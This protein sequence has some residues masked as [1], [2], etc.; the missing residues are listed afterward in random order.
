MHR[1]QSARQGLARL[2]GKRY[3]GWL[4]VLLYLLAALYLTAPI[5]SALTLRFVGAE[6]GDTYD[7]VRQVWWFKTALLNGDDIFEQSL[8]AYPEGFRSVRLWANPLQFFP[9]WLF[10][11]FLPLPAAF[12][13]GVLLTLTLNGWS[14]Y[15]LAR[16]RLTAMSRFP[17]FVAGLVF[18][19]FPTLQGYLLDG[20]I[21]MLALWPLP[22]LIVYLFDYAD[23]GGTRRF[24]IA[25]LLFVMVALGDTMRVFYVLA[26]LALLFVCARVQRRDQ[27]GA[28]RATFAVLAGCV[29][30]LLYLSPVIADLMDNPQLLTAGGRPGRSIDLLGLVSPSSANPFWDDIALHSQR[31][32]GSQLSGNA[33]Y[34]GLIGGILA[35][36]GI[37][38][39]REARW[40]LLV[41]FTAWILALGP[42]LRVNNQVLVGTVGGYPAVLPLPFAML[43]RLPIFELAQSPA[44]FMCLFAVMYALL[45]GFG[46]MVCCE[47]NLVQRRRPYARVIIAGIFV[48]MLLED[49]KLVGDFPSVTADV[50]REILDLSRQR[51]IHAVYNVPHDNPLAVNEALFLQTAHAKPLIAGLDTR[52]TTV[53]RARL[54]LLSKFQPSLLEDAGADI[55]IINKARALESGHLD[56]LHWRARQGLGDPLYEDQRYA[57]YETPVLRDGAPVVYAPLT[58]AQSHVTYIYKEQPG[59][60]EYSAVLEAQNRRVI[61][62]LNDTPLETL[63]VN[64]RIPLSFPLPMARRGYHAFRVAPDPPCPERVDTALLNCQRV[65]VEDVRITVL[66]DGA[67]YDP[68]RIEDGIILAGY[69]L[70]EAAE[71]EVIRIRFWWQFEADRSEKDVR[72]VHVLD[73][74]GRLAPGSPPDHHFGTLTAGSEVTE[75]V[76]LDKNMLEA[77]EHRVLTGWYQLPQA[78]R[79]DVLTEVEGAQD[80]TV[81]LGTI[82][83]RE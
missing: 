21:G 15:V 24:F 2:R 71:D 10:A 68:I 17:A 60:L 50:P 41:C 18:I 46:T 27:L 56:L 66:S 42:V 82:L 81:V 33:S 9:M 29:C 47:S 76:S 26:P 35:L 57:V 22:L 25:A 19:F 48:I 77:G 36:F 37:L 43:A 44:N 54:A 73:A 39:R 32:L 4:V 3:Q 23:Y 28:L 63:V 34:I 6:T 70:P 30:L 13:A 52:L 7:V 62:S 55:V 31:V 40:C 74:N 72:F 64:G 53:D 51:E 12:N 78:I 20:R 8:L 67:I 65:H 83:I 61:L 11:F 45:A 14:M 59:W 79:Y 1:L 49:F 16:R 80:D 69:L 58:D 38:Y 75:T 5:H